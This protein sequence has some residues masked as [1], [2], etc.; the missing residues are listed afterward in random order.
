MLNNLTGKE[1]KLF[2]Y[3]LVTCQFG[4]ILL[5]AIL[6]HY[7]SLSLVSILFS[8]L[9][10]ALGGYAIMVMKIGK[11]HVLPR[12]VSRSELVTKGPYKYIRHPMYT[13]VL[14][15][16]AALIAGDFSVVKSGIGIFLAFSLIIKLEYE[17]NLFIQRFPEYNAYRDNT[18]RLIPF[19]W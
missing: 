1:N 2:E 4:S 10:I 11:F 15:V 16:A 8:I 12:P 9:G 3:T 5:I 18:K 7:C 6:T 14:I 19:I 17:E 13:S